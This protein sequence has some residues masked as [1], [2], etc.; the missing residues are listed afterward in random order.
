MKK[1]HLSADINK[2][3]SRTENMRK[4]NEMIETEFVECMKLVETKSDMSFIIKDSEKTVEELKRIEKEIE[5]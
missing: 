2:L 1:I 3:M 4:V 5:V